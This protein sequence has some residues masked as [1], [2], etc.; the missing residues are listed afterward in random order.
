MEPTAVYAYD[1]VGVG[2]EGSY[3]LEGFYV[4]IFGVGHVYEGEEIGNRVRR[5]CSKYVEV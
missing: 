1:D 4:F 5:F 2:E 3:L